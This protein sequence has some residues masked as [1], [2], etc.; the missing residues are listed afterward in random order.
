MLLIML[1][2]SNSWYVVIMWQTRI[3]EVTALQTRWKSLTL[4]TLSCALP[5]SLLWR[6][7]KQSLCRNEL[8]L[9]WKEYAPFQRGAGHKSRTACGLEYKI[10]SFMD[11]I[12]KIQADA[13]I[14][15]I[16]LTSCFLWSHTQLYFPKEPGWRTPSQP[17]N[18]KTLQ[19]LKD[20]AQ[21]LLW[22]RA[23][24]PETRCSFRAS[25]PAVCHFACHPDHSNVASIW[26]SYYV[27]LA[28]SEW[29]SRTELV[30]LC[31]WSEANYVNPNYFSAG[32]NTN[33]SSHCFDTRGCVQA[34]AT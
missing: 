24:C 10:L 6:L 8:K 13:N 15:P 11:A 12:T 33:L 5:S 14:G 32:E 26:C 28:F 16:C 2:N 9:G 3:G 25:C 22:W 34:T 23:V 30:K 17:P 29:K 21:T 19:P 31:M 20:F 4:A 27:S 7:N 18:S 1:F